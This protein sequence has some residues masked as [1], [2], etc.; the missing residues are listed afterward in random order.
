MNAPTS[1]IVTFGGSYPGNLAAWFR[2]KYPHLTIGSVASSAPLRAVDDFYAYM[3]VV[4][5]AMVY[6]GGWTCREALAQAV[7]AVSEKIKA[8]EYAQLKKDFKLC[9]PITSPKDVWVFESN[10]MGNIQV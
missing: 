6:F 4:A 3:D 8:G 9:D 5:D 10:L 2:Q 7:I 1:P